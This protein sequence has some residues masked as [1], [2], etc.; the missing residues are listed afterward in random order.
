[1]SI[2]NRILVWVGLCLL[3]ALGSVVAYSS[4]T[5]RDSALQS[6]QAEILGV[7]R[8]KAHQISGQIEVALDTAR[9]LAIALSTVKSGRASLTRETV[10]S[11][12]RATLERYPDFVGVYTA[13]EPD[14][15]DGMDS[16]HVRHSGHDAT[17]RF[18]PYWNRDKE[19]K[20]IVA[21]LVDYENTALENTGTGARKGDY[22]LLPRETKRECVIEPYVYPVQ[23]K[24]T[25]MASM[26][27]PVLAKN[28]FY[29]IGGVDLALD[30]LQSLVDKEDIFNHTGKLYIISHGGR[31]AAASGSPEMVGRSLG[32]QF[33]S[34]AEKY[35][36]LVR[37]GEEQVQFT[38]Q[39]VLAFVPIHFG[40]ASASWSVMIQ[41]PK[42][43]VVRAAAQMMWR[44]LWLGLFLGGAA[45]VGLWTISSAIAKPIGKTVQVAQLIAQGDLGQATAAI[46]AIEVEFRSGRREPAAG[47]GGPAAAPC[48]DET[49]QLLDAISTMT[50]RLAALLGQAQRSVV[51]LVSG[52]TQIAAAAKGHEVT[53]REFEGLTA[54]IATAVREISATTRELAQ[55]MERVK[56]V[57]AATG[58]L[59]DTGR[60]GLQNMEGVMSRLSEATETISE[61]LSVISERASTISGVVVT[62]TKVAAQTNLLSLNA[63]LEAERAGAHGHGFGVVA[64][65]IG[66]LADQTAV[67]TLDI[68]QMVAQMQASVSEGVREMNQFREGVRQGVG[69]VGKI[70]AQMGQIIA[71]VKDLAPQF[72]KVNEGMKSQSQGAEQISA[73]MSQLSDGARKTTR[74]MEQSNEVTE[75]LSEAC[76]ALQEEISRF[77]V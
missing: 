57:E 65:E 75:H 73:A 76:R 67:A 29:G 69:A 44:Q 22:Y 60:L 33:P 4:I 55:T 72:E 64:M 68:E 12:L 39:S 8:G 25:L 46:A 15:F 18:I 70:G 16:G 77:K 17:G 21:P 47:A 42:E 10:N 6:A 23:G 5:A 71:G 35:L 58:R 28:R 20:I 37:N 48:R 14:A 13:W 49:R 7:A 19:G 9:E 32:A 31:I 11:I 41:V 24:D 45:L 38:G 26:V 1:M 53:A 52:S 43:R 34:A 66:R 40:Q 56:E 50:V 74:S 59:A 2:R 27:V 63:T 62:I 3:I 30:F 36:T 54:D 51:Q 61:K